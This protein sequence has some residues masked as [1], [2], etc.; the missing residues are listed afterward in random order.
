MAR[1]KEFRGLRPGRDI[2][3]SIAELPYDVLTEAEIGDIAGKNKNSFYHITYLWI[4]EKG[5]KG[6]R[7]RHFSF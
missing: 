4:M 6:L 7:R 3:S 2:V 1:I 5:L